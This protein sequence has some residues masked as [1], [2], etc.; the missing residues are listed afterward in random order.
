MEVNFMKKYQNLGSL[1][2]GKSQNELGGLR[3]LVGKMIKMI[4]MVKMKEF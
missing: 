4:K 1:K 2:S 3:K